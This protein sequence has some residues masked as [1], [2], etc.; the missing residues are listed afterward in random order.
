[1]FPT[2]TT[3]RPAGDPDMTRYRPNHGRFAEH[4]ARYALAVAALMAAA[5]TGGGPEYA[6]VFFSFGQQLLPPPGGRGPDRP[7]T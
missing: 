3:Q 5:V 7:A 4:H 1:M 2:P 6:A